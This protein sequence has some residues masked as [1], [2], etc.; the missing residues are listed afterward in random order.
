MSRRKE[1]SEKICLNCGEQ[2]RGRYCPVCGQENIEPKE[3]LWQLV[4]QFFMDLLHIDGKFFITLKL[5]LLKPAFLSTEYLRG[6]RASYIHPVR[7]YIFTAFVFFIVLFSLQSSMFDLIDEGN[8][9]NYDVSKESL[10]KQTAAKKDNPGVSVKLM[11]DSSIEAA[12]RKPDTKVT[13]V[14]F[15]GVTMS[16]KDYDSIQSHLPKE[17]RDGWIIQRINLKNIRIREKYAHSRE[18][19]EILLVDRYFR[20]FPRMMF[21][22]LPV[23]AFVLQLLYINKRK[24]LNYVGHSIF[25]LHCYSATYLLMLMAFFFNWLHELLHWWIIGFLKIALICTVFFYLYKAL[26]N[27]YRERRAR[28]I[29]KFFILNLMVLILFILSAVLLLVVSL[30]QT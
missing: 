9:V 4:S 6:K 16:V 7:M 15:A 26:R 21:F 3:N 10:P 5:L 8:N 24:Q 30:Y 13:P 20:Y 23:V 18:T 11:A 14:V 12:T 22:F 25:V 2:L 17:K 28:T 27:F 29:F 1:R 19:F